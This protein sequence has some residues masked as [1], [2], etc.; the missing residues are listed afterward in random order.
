MI[1]TI[2]K[3]AKIS[4]KDCLGKHPLTKP[5]KTY[6]ESVKKYYGELNE[7]GGL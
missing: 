3:R 7:Y 1:P 2:E 5:I 4:F 6:T